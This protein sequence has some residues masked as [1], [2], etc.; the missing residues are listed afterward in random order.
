FPVVVCTGEPPCAGW[1]ELD[2]DRHLLVPRAHLRFR[3]AELREQ[4]RVGDQLEMRLLVDP[5]PEGLTPLVLIRGRGQ[6]PTSLW[7]AFRT[8]LGVWDLKLTYDPHL[9]ADSEVSI[10]L[11][12]VPRP[13]ER[14]GPNRALEI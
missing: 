12:T 11:V 4:T 6:A 5:V 14:P 9:P 1:A 7:P 10:Y 3:V 8:E 13:R 2:P